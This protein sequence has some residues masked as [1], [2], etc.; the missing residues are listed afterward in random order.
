MSDTAV[1]KN[2]NECPWCDKGDPGKSYCPFCGRACGRVSDPLLATD[3]L[4]KPQKRIEVPEHGTF[5]IRF[6]HLS[7]GVVTIECDI[8]QSSNISFAGRPQYEKRMTV[9]SSEKISGC[10][11]FSVGDS[12]NQPSGHITFTLD[13]E[14]RDPDRIWKKKNKRSFRLSISGR[15]STSSEKWLCGSRCLMFPPGVH[16]QNLMIYNDSAVERTFSFDSPKGFIAESEE[17]PELNSIRIPGY[18]SSSIRLR[19]LRSQSKSDTR[20]LSWIIS[21]S[22]EVKIAR[23][24][25]KKES[26]AK[27]LTISIDLGANSARIRARWPKGNPIFGR[28]RGQTERIGGESVSCSMVLDKNDR[29]FHFGSKADE[30][31]AG[32]SMRNGC[33]LKGGALAAVTGLKTD[34]VCGRESYSKANPEWTNEYLMCLLFKS[35]WKIV[36]DWA[37]GLFKEKGVPVP[38][39][40]RFNEFFASPEYVIPTPSFGSPEEEEAYRGLIR[41]ALMSSVPGDD[42]IS[43]DQITFISWPQAI[44]NY[45]SSA[46]RNLISEIPDGGRMCFIDSGAGETDVAVG[47]L[48]NRDG[49]AVFEQEFNSRLS[50][51][52]NLRTGCGIKDPSFGG[53]ALDAITA[54]IL[55]KD[56]N[57]ILEKPVSGAGSSLWQSMWGSAEQFRGDDKTRYSRKIREKLSKEGTVTLKMVPSGGGETILSVDASK[58]NEQILR[59]LLADMSS[60]LIQSMSA[61]GIDPKSMASVILTGGLNSCSFQRRRLLEKFGQEHPRLGESFTRE[62]TT[63]AAADGA[64]LGAE[65]YFEKSPVTLKIRDRNGLVEETLARENETFRPSTIM[66]TLEFGDE[67]VIMLDLVAESGDLSLSDIV[68]TAICRQDLS[69]GGDFGDSATFH[70]ALNRAECTCTS[71]TG[72]ASSPGWR[73]ILSEPEKENKDTEKRNG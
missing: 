62:E 42:G 56:L 22:S 49:R 48:R 14:A 24:P 1:T 3:R 25:A 40:F 55:G 12:R 44:V 11:E 41:K 70:I 31:I 38:G 50:I 64:A 73:V 43:A 32:T 7:G 30:I 18:G 61:K 33:M 60:R 2:Q 39:G 58:Y 46:K 8:T 37:R 65:V 20:A 69:A 19:E 52:E 15:V 71:Y 21:G 34:A 13:N 9:Q 53:D 72:G 36:D 68:A 16:S 54:F 4:S 5:T 10:F 45:C 57:K 6:D 27:E 67:G 59:P 17:N 29:E 63:C 51:N 26:R 35:L 47:V 66:K 28:K 23:I